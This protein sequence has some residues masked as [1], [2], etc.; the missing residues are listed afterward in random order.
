MCRYIEVYFG[1]YLHTCWGS[2]FLEELKQIVIASLIM[3]A[4]FLV[5]YEAIGA[6]DVDKEICTRI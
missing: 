3:H 6:N 4:E 2:R 1:V 5:T